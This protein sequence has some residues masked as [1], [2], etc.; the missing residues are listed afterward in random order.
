MGEGAG[1]GHG[2]TGGEGGGH[3]QNQNQNG[4][5]PREDPEP[6]TVT[7]KTEKPPPTKKSKKNKKSAESESESDQED[8][9]KKEKK[10]KA[11]EEKEKKKADQQALEELRQV[12]FFVFFSSIFVLLWSLSSQ[13]ETTAQDDDDVPQSTLVQLQKYQVAHEKLEFPLKNNISVRSERRF[14]QPRDLDPAH[15]EKLKQDMINDP[16]FS[17]GAA[18]IWVTERLLREMGFEDGSETPHWI[19]TL[20]ARILSGDLPIHPFRGMHTLEAFNQLSEYVTWEETV[21]LYL[22]P[23]AC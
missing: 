7:D 5:R 13:K 12:L 18:R 19:P 2:A 23:A 11:R 14:C 20:I 17:K 4:K 9:E 21:V 22:S 10:E 8:K 6:A 3:Q 15:V 1:T 16:T